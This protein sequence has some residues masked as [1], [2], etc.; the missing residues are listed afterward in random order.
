MGM[1][2]FNRMRRLKAE[3]EVEAKQNDDQNAQKP[4]KDMKV[5][6]LK[7]LAK[8]KGIEGYGSMKKDEL[9]EA[10]QAEEEGDTDGT[11]NPDT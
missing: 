11:D 10:L 6:E 5:D 2:A 9:L 1:A 8:E 7:D 4:L 3:A